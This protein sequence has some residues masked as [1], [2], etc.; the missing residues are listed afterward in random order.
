MT[1]RPEVPDE[2]ET[3]PFETERTQL[4]FSR[5]IDATESPIPTTKEALGSKGLGLVEMAGLGLPVPPGF[6]LTTDSRREFRDSGDQIRWSISIEIEHQLR[7][8]EEKIGKKLGDPTNPLIVSVR[9]GAAVSMPGAMITILNVGINDE[10]IHSLANDIG[11]HA[12]WEAYFQL[13]TD[14]GTHAYGVEPSAFQVIRD[15][16]LSSFAVST[17]HELPFARLQLMVR[18]AKTLIKQKG[19]EFP[20]NPK[21]QLSDATTAV[22]HSWMSP[23]AQAI[24]KQFG[25]PETIGTA[26]IVQQMVWGNSEKDGAGSAVLFTRD[27]KT[28]GTKPVIYYAHHAQGPSVVGNEGNIQSQTIASLAVPDLIK[29]QISD[30]ARRLEAYYGHPQDVELTFDGTT[31]WVLQTRDER[32]APPAYFRWLKERINMGQL[33][34]D[35][36]KRH[37]R[38]VDLTA[39]LVPDLDPDA[40]AEAKRTGRHVATGIRISLGNGSGRVVRTIDEAGQYADEPV[41]LALGTATLIDIASL[42]KK[43]VGLVAANG[44]AGSHIGVQASPL[45]IPV[46]F[47]IE[48]EAVKK[49]EFATVDG[50]SGEVFSGIIPRSTNG[51]SKIL[52]AE[53]RLLVETWLDERIENPWRFVG[54][55]E[56]TH[57]YIQEAQSALE[58]GKRNGYVAPKALEYVVLNALIPKE[59]RMNYEIVSIADKSTERLTAVQAHVRKQ[60][61]EIVASGHDATIRTCVRERGQGVAPWWYIT[62]NQDIEDLFTNPQFSKYGSLEAW[63]DKLDIPEILIGTVPKGKLD[64]AIQLQECVW[65]LFCGEAGD[66]TLQIGLYTA[67]HRTFDTVQKTNLYTLTCRYDAQVNQIIPI[68]SKLDED[69]VGIEYV[70]QMIDYV[71][72]TVFA[73]WDHYNLQKVLTAVTEAFPDNT[74]PVLEGQARIDPNN[75][76][77]RWCLIYGMK[78][79]PIDKKSSQGET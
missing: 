27:A 72:R 3:S 23:E 35:E 48:A 78:I 18:E 67:H 10:T 39:L 6:I 22:F 63:L 5:A 25:Y 20:D 1:P 74:T 43:V 44:G 32:V 56:D 38:T 16:N 62:T 34:E 66:V 8:L 79:D 65:E 42:P 36:A 15:S 69:L 40:I 14:L 73:W 57:G 33:T 37:M 60:L 76:E 41:V 12:A 51:I 31:V 54:P 71:G 61:A 68:A 55:E 19:D 53:E 11:E 26:A 47:A 9:S 58:D 45:D 46:V 29:I 52:T 21:V 28:L 59:T 30:I 7:S 4:R 17:L 49:L 64:P 50:N 75:L 2:T 13:V 77:N 24:R 70:Q